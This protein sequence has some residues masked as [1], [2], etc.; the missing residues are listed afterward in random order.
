MEIAGY[1]S[2]FYSKCP[3]PVVLYDLSSDFKQP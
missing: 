1:F 3:F 2:D